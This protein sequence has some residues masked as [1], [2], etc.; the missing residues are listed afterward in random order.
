MGFLDLSDERLT[1]FIGNLSVCGSLWPGSYIISGYT[2]LYSN[3]RVGLPVGTRFKT[4]AVLYL[5]SRFNPRSQ[6]AGCGAAPDL[7]LFGLSPNRR[8][9]VAVTPSADPGRNLRIKAFFDVV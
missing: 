2:E 5:A 9:G 7:C 3:A 1:Y 6:V 8:G 4:G